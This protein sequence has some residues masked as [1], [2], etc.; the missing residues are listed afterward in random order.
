MELNIALEVLAKYYNMTTNKIDSILKS[1][2]EEINETN[3][4]FPFNGKINEDKCKA[5][6][7]NHGLY[8]QCNKKTKGE[9]CSCCNKLKYGSIEE[10][11][12]INK[13][14]FVT[15]SGKK[16]VEYEKIIQKLGF[17]Y[18]QVITIFRKY[19]FEYNLN[20]NAFKNNDKKQRGRPKKEVTKKKEELSEECEEIEVEEVIVDEIKYYKTDENVLLNQEYEIVGIYNNGKLEKL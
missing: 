11:I 18:E 10:R 12:N 8:T 13:G 3:F 9:F 14:E 17:T 15:K 20:E 16:E 19:N 7:F 1:N 6:V 2:M 5:I 4:T